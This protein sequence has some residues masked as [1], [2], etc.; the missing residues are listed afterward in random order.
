M[1]LFG[2]QP[3]VAAAGA[4]LSVIGAR[5]FICSGVRDVEGLPQEPFIAFWCDRQ[6]LDLVEQ[7]AKDAIVQVEEHRTEI[8]KGVSVS[9][10]S[11]AEIGRMQQFAERLIALWNAKK[12]S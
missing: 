7:A 1:S 8:G 11:R 12:A 4:A 2:M 5:P 3:G 9:V 6:H 10:V